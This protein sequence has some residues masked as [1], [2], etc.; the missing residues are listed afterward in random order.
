MRRGERVCHAVSMGLALIATATSLAAVIVRDASVALAVIAVA[1]SLLFVLVLFGLWFSLRRQYSVQ[2][3]VLWIVSGI[4]SLLAIVALGWAAWPAAFERLL[5]EA[6]ADVATANSAAFLLFALVA[7][8]IAQFLQWRPLQASV[9]QRQTSAILALLAL[10]SA[11]GEVFL[12]MVSGKALD[13]VPL[14]SALAFSALAFRLICVAGDDTWPASVFTLPSTASAKA[15]G[16]S[17]SGFVMLVLVLLGFVG[18]T[19]YYY[20]ARE[21]ALARDAANANLSTIADLKAQTIASW[22]DNRL[23]SAKLLLTPTISRD[24]LDALLSGKIDTQRENDI[25]QWMRALMEANGY[26]A[27][28]FHDAQGQVKL[29]VGSMLADSEA[30]RARIRSTLTAHTVQVDDIYRDP[31]SGK[32][33]LDFRLPLY[34]G[35]VNTGLAKGV[36]LLRL[37]PANYLYPLVQTWPTNSA[38]AETLLVRRDGDSVLFLNELRHRSGTALRLHLP[39]QGALGIPALIAVGSNN[40]SL[41]E[42]LD[43]RGEPVLAAVRSVPQSSWYLVAK[44]DRA[45]IYAPVNDRIVLLSSLIAVLGLAALLGAVILWRQRSYAQVWRE[46]QL[47]RAS[48][49]GEQRYHRLVE[50][51]SDALMID[52]ENGNVVYV[53][54]RFLMMYGYQYE[55]VI[56]RHFSEFSAPQWRDSGRY[57]HQQR[58]AGEPVASTF[59]Y[60]ALRKD[61][62]QF[63]GEVRV[64]TVVE[65]GRLIGTQ[66]TVQDITERKRAQELQAAL[67]H[68]SEAAHDASNMDDLYRRI[69]QIISALL[70]AQNFYVALYDEASDR[71]SFPYFIDAHDPEPAPQPLGEIS[72]TAVVIRSGEA[73]LLHP[74]TQSDAKLFGGTMVGTAPVEW[75]GVPLRSQARTIGVLAVQSY[76]SAV[77]FSESDKALLQFVST[78]VAAAI[79]RKRTEAAMRDSEEK[80]RA[81]FEESPN[82]IGLFELPGG[83]MVEANKAAVDVF[84][85][86]YGELIGKT[87]SELGIWAVEAERQQYLAQLRTCA[88]VRDFETTMRRDNGEIV[89]VLYSGALVSISGQSY[90]L[91][92]MQDISARK[93]AEQQL[94]E[95]VAMIRNLELALNEHALVSITDP[96][97]RIIDV[98]HAFCAV[99]GY[100]R[101]EVIGRSHDILNSGYHPADFFEQVWRTIE[102]GRVWH[103]EVC[104]RAKDGALLWLDSTIVPFL[105][106]TG[107]PYQYVS[108]NTVTTERKRAEQWQRHYADI[109]GLISAESPLANVLERI[110]DFAERQSDDAFAMVQW[111][112]GQ[113]HLTARGSKAQAAINEALAS[114]SDGAS[115]TLLATRSLLALGYEALPDCVGPVSADSTDAEFKLRISEPIIA[116]DQRVLGNLILCQTQG[117]ESQPELVAMLRQSAALAAVAIERAQHQANQRL[118]KVVFEQTVE[119]IMVSDQHDLIVMVNPAF[120][121]LT[122]YAAADVLGK[123]P[124]LL[125]SGR[126]EPGF[127]QR[128]EDAVA[129]EDWWQGEFWCRHRAGESRPMLLSV[130]AVRDAGGEIIQRIRVMADISEQKFQAARIEQLAFYDSLTG[131]PNRA[132]FLDRLDHSLDAARRHGL[133]G[134]LLFLDLDRFKEIN[135]SQGHAVGD[136]ALVEVSRRFQ[137]LLRKEETLA[138]LGGDE[139]VLIAE[140]ANQE[141]AAMIAE[142]ILHALCAPMQLSDQATHLS[143]SIGIALYP[144]DGDSVGDLIK[145]AD[146][147]MYRAKAMSGGYRFYQAAMGAALQERLGLARRLELAIEQG[148]L[149][150][151]YQPRVALASET[152]QGAEALLRWHDDEFGEVSPAQFIPIAEERGLIGPL[153]DWVIAETCRQMAQW[154]EQGLVFPGTI[155]INL[156]ALQLHLPD[157]VDKLLARID[158]AGLTTDRFEIELTESSMMADPAAAI[159]IL[160]QLHGA[161]FSLAID[162]F[163][164]GYSS[165]VYLKRFAVD[166]IK[167]DMSFVSDMLSDRNDAAIVATIVAMSRSLG[168]RTTAEG[169]ESAEQAEALLQLGCDFA[170]G[171]HF[172]RPE[173]ADVFARRWLKPVRAKPWES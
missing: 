126:H 10:A 74:E 3:S 88:S 105:D 57:R 114:I 161:G 4:A 159:A 67:L 70:P 49:I 119:A 141:T 55:D 54:D 47:Q 42:G 8:F 132:L 81:V 104:D 168:L 26:A 122:G 64:S 19:G 21:A 165:L 127:Y 79:E 143:A 117:S 80:Y 43:Y 41:V 129:H 50:N 115:N 1:S 51:I 66:S 76:D 15:K 77:R 2:A 60:Q 163:G 173:P 38:S 25:L 75:L 56:G 151:H 96:Q 32:I 139:F 133:K 145:H 71:V 118:A 170:Q 23:A 30:V 40:A 6:G 65:D 134:A 9:W 144:D 155:A 125:E 63:W 59:E 35:D 34:L 85:R 120:E 128:I 31:V 90:A 116:A 113:A 167:I 156:S 112:E 13:A 162:D 98:N 62:S 37:D 109:L 89:P 7:T 110:A 137:R 130:V 93:Q 153:G 29:S 146:I 166:N 124:S 61:G 95:S 14:L 123:N 94:R 82:A 28:A 131:L 53:N 16:A 169:V 18:A 142:R 147:A 5:M 73:V 102:S 58:F 148:Q 108:I 17:A 154:H 36:L 69:H 97:G 164:T 106:A 44:T 22:Y 86:P 20:I 33:S 45:E 140:G 111:Q 99:S 52:D 149:H 160:D 48:A 87:A 46:L 157:M 92:V 11:L 12:C 138:R 136:L 68:I 72:L 100:S 152:I 91:S 158:S 39:L 103:G 135:D 171:Y 172:G 78:Q 150:L 101:Q 84:A 24:D 27:V 107:K 83:R 121:R